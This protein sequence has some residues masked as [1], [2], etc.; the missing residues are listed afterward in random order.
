MKSDFGDRKTLGTMLAETEEEHL[1]SSP[2][3]AGDL[4]HEGGKS[5]MRELIDTIEN[6]RHVKQLYIQ[7][8]PKKELYAAHRVI[9]FRFF[10][11]L[12]KPLMEDDMDVWFVDNQKDILRLEWSLPHWSEMDAFLANEDYYNKNLIQ[13]IKIYKAAQ[14]K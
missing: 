9:Y 7:V 11:R 4:A 8:I 1:K 6:H 5:Y 12:S 2:V 3:E 14:K 10:A 13:W